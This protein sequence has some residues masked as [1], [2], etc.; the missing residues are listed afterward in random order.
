MDA[1]IDVKSEKDEHRLMVI[2]LGVRKML[3]F[4]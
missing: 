4:V 1:A 3:E 2:G